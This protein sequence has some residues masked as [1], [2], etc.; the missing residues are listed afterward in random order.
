MVKS[1]EISDWL[2]EN[3]KIQEQLCSRHSRYHLMHYIKKCH[4]KILKRR[5]KRK[6]SICLSTFFFFLSSIDSHALA[7]HCGHSIHIFF[8]LVHVP[9]TY[10]WNS[11]R[12]TEVKRHDYVVDSVLELWSLNDYLL[13]SFI[14]RLWLDKQLD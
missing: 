10:N 4:F 2:T 13:W 9:P 6:V 14:F 11:F 3:P 12:Y 8:R 1:K 7:C 5:E